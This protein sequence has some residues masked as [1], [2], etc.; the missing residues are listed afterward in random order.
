MGLSKDNLSALYRS[1][2]EDSYGCL[3]FLFHLE[4]EKIR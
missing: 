4:D 1:E 3:N 2:K